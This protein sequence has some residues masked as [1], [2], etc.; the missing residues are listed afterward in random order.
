MSKNVF[1]IFRTGVIATPPGKA[2]GHNGEWEG[3]WRGGVWRD[4][5]GRDAGRDGGGDAARTRFSIG[6]S[7]SL[8]TIDCFSHRRRRRR[9]IW[10]VTR[11]IQPTPSARPVHLLQKSHAFTL[12]LNYRL[13]INFVF[14]QLN[15]IYLTQ[16]MLLYIMAMI[17]GSTSLM[18][19]IVDIIPSSHRPWAEIFKMASREPIM[20][21]SSIELGHTDDWLWKSSRFPTHLT[22]ATEI[23]S[24]Y[25]TVT[26]LAFGWAIQNREVAQSF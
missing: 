6:W 20:Q 26:E 16:K 24:D 3:N 9:N 1:F 12:I 13:L 18:G 5:A 14:L 8:V 4:A 11:P 7:S 2:A 25:A 23:H 10:N 22:L 19:V 17:D 15:T 21:R